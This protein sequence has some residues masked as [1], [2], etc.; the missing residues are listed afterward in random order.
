M[1]RNL[2]AAELPMEVVTVVTDRNENLPFDVAPM[3]NVVAS[4]TTADYTIAGLE[5]RVALER[6]SL[7]DLISCCG[8]ERRDS[9]A[10]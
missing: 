10:S 8:T 3:Q 6:K 7:P 9:S 5:D 4:L 2:L 1:T